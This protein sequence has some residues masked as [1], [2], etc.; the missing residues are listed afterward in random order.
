MLKS[1]LIWPFQL[2]NVESVQ[3]LQPVPK[4]PVMATT[5]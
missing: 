1:S 5:M 4:A 2:L 3:V